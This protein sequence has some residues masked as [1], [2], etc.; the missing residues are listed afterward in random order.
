ML[1]EVFSHAKTPHLVLAEDLGHLLVRLEIL[2]VLGILELVLL[3]V[4]PKL[5]DTLA[6]GGFA[7][8]DN[9]CQVVG[10]T[11]LLSEAGSFWHLQ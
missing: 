5:L 9:V 8:P 1:A 3:D 6:P 7:L 2:L 10:Q 4:G 11:I